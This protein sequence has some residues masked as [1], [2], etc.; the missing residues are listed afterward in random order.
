MLKRFVIAKSFRLH[1]SKPK[2]IPG[3][4]FVDI[5]KVRKSSRRGLLG[6]Q[7]CILSQKSVPQGPLW[8]ITLYFEPES[9]PAGGFWADKIRRPSVGRVRTCIGGGLPPPYPPPPWGSP[10]A[11]TKILGGSCLKDANL[12]EGLV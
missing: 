9:R 11:S 3:N 4:I 6:R 2:K 10:L 1:I 12:S 7:N 5:S 8:R